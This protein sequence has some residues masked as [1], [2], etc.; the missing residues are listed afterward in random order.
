[1]AEQNYSGERTPEVT[2]WNL[3]Q[4]RIALIGKLMMDGEEALLDFNISSDKR[5]AIRYQCWRSISLAIDNR[6][7]GSERKI[8]K[9]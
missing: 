5:I 1:M 2:A 8:V 7:S 3:N 9:K 4:I 6:I